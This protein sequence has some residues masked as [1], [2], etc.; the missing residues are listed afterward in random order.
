MSKCGSGSPEMNHGYCSIPSSPG[1]D[2]GQQPMVSQQVR[3]QNINRVNGQQI[4]PSFETAHTTTIRS[5]TSFRL[6]YGQRHQGDMRQKQNASSASKPRQ[7]SRGSGS[8]YSS[9][10]QHPPPPSQSP[11]VQQAHDSLNAMQLSS[12]PGGFAALSYGEV[13]E[14]LASMPAVTDGPNDDHLR[15]PVGARH[16]SPEKET[17]ASKLVNT[18]R[19]TKQ[20]SSS[21]QQNKETKNDTRKKSWWSRRKEA[22]QQADQHEQQVQALLVS[23]DQCPAGYRWRRTRKGYVCGGGNH[24]V[25]KAEIDAALRD[26][27]Y[28]PQ[29]W[30]HV[31]RWRRALGLYLVLDVYQF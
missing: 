25:P 24:I 31:P 7:Q 5:R 19:S 28:I 14:A 17:P 26:S 23:L 20:V 29:V 9:G 22:D 6:S 18:A 1:R 8:T 27:M 15:F 21:Q 2:Y 30:P 13:H 10:A 11:M 16:K 4:E 12:R 3:W